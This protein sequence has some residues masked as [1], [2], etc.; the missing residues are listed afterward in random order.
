M[1]PGIIGDNLNAT[2]Y[3]SYNEFILHTTS[4][5]S[6]KNH[7]LKKCRSQILNTKAL[8]RKT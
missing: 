5:K 6:V 3:F 1:S 7:R 4:M 8:E 2:K